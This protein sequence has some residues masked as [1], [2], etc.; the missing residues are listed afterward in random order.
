MWPGLDVADTALGIFIAREV[1]QGFATMPVNVAVDDLTVPA[2]GGPEWAA[3][4]A[5]RQAVEPNAVCG[6]AFAEPQL[7]DK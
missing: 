1:D 2:Q 4:G 6:H 5:T 3:A 7:M